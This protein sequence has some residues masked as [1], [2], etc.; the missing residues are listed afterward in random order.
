MSQQASPPALGKVRV[1]A[2]QFHY[3][4]ESRFN[5]KR[6]IF[7]SPEENLQDTYQKTFRTGSVLKLQVVYSK[8]SK[9]ETEYCNLSEFVKCF[10]P[11]LPQEGKKT[12]SAA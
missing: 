4:N 3:S 1:T 12:K 10:S 9:K 8:N 6:R 11:K 2:E 7:T 5:H